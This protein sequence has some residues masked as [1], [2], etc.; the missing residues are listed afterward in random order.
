LNEG[1][2]PAVLDVR[3]ESEWQAGHVPGAVHVENGDLAWLPEEALNARLPRQGPVVV[4]CA[5]GDRS[6]AAA[7]VLRRRGY[8]NLAHLEGGFAAWA[9][10]GGEVARG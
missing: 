3:M 7:S 5:H 8:H 4:H 9:A 6:T 1:D 2:P 10:A